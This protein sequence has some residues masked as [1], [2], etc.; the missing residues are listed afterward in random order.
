MGLVQRLPE[1][2]SWLTREAASWESLSDAAYKGLVRDWH[3]TYSSLVES[4]NSRARGG[5]A[6]EAVQKRL[7]AEVVLFSGVSVPRVANLGGRGA[8]A[9]RADALAGLNLDVLRRQELL[10]AAVDLSWCCLFSHETGALV[11][12]QFYEAS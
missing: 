12:E 2:E 9:Y 5:R 10:L 7:P 8:A 11:H 3:A 6:L 1:V 4:G